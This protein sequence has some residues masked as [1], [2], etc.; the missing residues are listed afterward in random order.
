V[1]VSPL[2]NL[3]PARASGPRL[4]Q[5]RPLL[6]LG[7][8]GVAGTATLSLAPDRR[9]LEVSVRLDGGGAALAI[10]L[11]RIASHHLRGGSGSY[12]HDLLLLEVIAGRRRSARISIQE[13]F[14]LEDRGSFLPFERVSDLRKLEIDLS[15]LL[16]SSIDGVSVEG[17]YEASATGPA[18]AAYLAE[19]MLTE[20]KAAERSVGVVAA[21]K[22]LELANLY[23][24][25]LGSSEAHASS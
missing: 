7:S 6:A 17:A 5:R 9:S 8:S 20:I 13:R 10:R 15:A 19:R 16:A 1:V 12:D 23:A 14:S 25:R 18:P 2:L 4:E 11:R 22:H 24:R 3:A 21:C